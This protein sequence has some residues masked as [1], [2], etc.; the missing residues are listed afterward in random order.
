MTL[1]EEKADLEAIDRAKAIERKTALLVRYSLPLIF[2]FSWIIVGSYGREVLYFLPSHGLGHFYESRLGLL[3]AVLTCIIIFLWTCGTYFRAE[4]VT[5][6]G[7]LTLSLYG[8]IFI[9]G[10]WILA[11]KPAKTILCDCVLLRSPHLDFARNI[12]GST[13]QLQQAKP[14]E[15]NLIAFVGSSQINLGIDEKLV[16]SRL[17]NVRTEKFCLPGMVPLQYLLFQNS[18][19]K[20]EAKV[21]ICWLSEFDFFREHKVPANRLRWN[22]SL[23]LWFEYNSLLSGSEK[24]RNRVE[25]VDLLS[26]SL[27]SMWR[28]RELW[29]MFAFRFWWQFDPQEERASEAEKQIGARLANL[30]Q[31]REN[32]KRN[33]QRTEMIEINFSAF[34][35]FASRLNQQG[36]QM[37]VIEGE[38]HP[39]AMFDYP[40]EFRDETQ[41]RLQTLSARY[42][43][44][45]FTEEQR[46]AFPD[47]LWADALHLTPEGS[48]VLT[49]WLIAKLSQHP[50]ISKA[51]N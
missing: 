31:G 23:P 4:S 35:D 7:L 16:V 43:F 26:G 21:V 9:G 37:I 32:L 44:L 39:Q 41:K 10:N 2:L 42:G 38:C 27:S 12:A 50:N 14:S 24:Y 30:A 5:T 8:C 22:M 3:V 20:K 40:S 1:P 17:V 29:Q 47:R 33:I 36:V 13:L 46:P 19:Q 25:M 34:E 18:L 6:N 28:Q 11:T 48:K 49:E 15:K 51:A 45:Y